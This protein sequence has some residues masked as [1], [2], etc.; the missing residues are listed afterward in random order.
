MPLFDKYSQTK[1]YADDVVIMG[2]RLQDV[3]VFRYWSKKR[4]GN[5]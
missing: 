4:I 5:K 3:E 2:G 1:A